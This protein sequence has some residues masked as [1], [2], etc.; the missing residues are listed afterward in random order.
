MHIIINTNW[1]IGLIVFALLVFLIV[2]SVV[3]RSKA[4]KKVLEALNEG[5][6]ESLISKLKDK[7]TNI[8]E[9]AVE[10]L[11]KMKDPRAI[12][13]LIEIL[14]KE[15]EGDILVKTIDAL[16]EIEDPKVISPLISTLNHKDIGTRWF[17]CQ[18]IEKLA[19]KGII[20]Y[21]A[22]EPLILILKKDSKYVIKEGFPYNAAE[23]A[24]KVITG[25]DFGEDIQKWELWW[26]VHKDN[27][28]RI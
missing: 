16:I 7:D 19:R 28:N 5:G 13:P 22:V 14:N 8:V 27:I 9:A 2:L 15:E 4:K 23:E 12:E 26:E 6:I 10:A 21:Q 18:I 20:D 3:R 24:L 11:G 17:A 25:Q 1:V